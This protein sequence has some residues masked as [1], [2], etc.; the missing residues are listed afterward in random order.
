MSN[1][2]SDFRKSN[3]GLHRLYVEYAV[4][5][6]A[7]IN[8]ALKMLDARGHTCLSGPMCALFAERDK[9]IAEDAAFAEASK[10]L[11]IVV[12]VDHGNSPDLEDEQGE[13]ADTKDN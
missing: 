13:P 6:L 12:A 8:K 3:P 4:D 2:T 10:L 1:F 5:D 7:T 11:R 9:L